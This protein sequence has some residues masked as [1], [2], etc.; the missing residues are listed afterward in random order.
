M[1]GEPK[2]WLDYLAQVWHVLLAFF[3][4]LMAV[5]ASGHAILKKRDT[6]AAV[7]WVAL[8]WLVPLLGPLLYFT[9]GINRLR[10]RA[11]QLRATHARYQTSAG[12]LTEREQPLDTVTR[13]APS[14]APLVRLGNQVVHQPLL[15]GN[16][17]EPLINGDAAFPAMVAAID[18]AKHTITFATYIFDQGKA[19]TMFVDA[20]SRAMQRGVEV[21][22]LIDDTGARYSW[23]SIVPKLK[24]A[25]IPVARFL[26]T[27]V[28]FRAMA[29]NLR[30]HRK[31]LV[32]DGHTAFTGGMNVR[33]GH[34]VAQKPKR[35]V[36]DVH[37]RLRGPVVS[38]LQEV[39]AD[40]WLFCTQEELRGEKWFPPL[41][42]AGPVLARSVPDGPDDH[43][44][45]IR[46]TILGAVSCAQKRIRIVNPYFLP[47]RGL[48]SALNVAALRGVQV[49]II[50]PQVNNLPFVHW[51]MMAQLWQLLERGCRVWLSEPPFDHSKLMVVDGEWSF[52]GSSNFD[53]RSLRLNFE[54]NVECYC[55]KLAADLE[56][57]I[58]SKLAKAHQ[59][60]LR[61]V[62]AR[63]L[64]I[65]LRDGVA[66]LLTPYL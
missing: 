4:L 26:P 66:R 34:L 63:P 59:L 24:Q 57:H 49:D 61:E 64:H 29:I 9:F 48:I 37:F 54:L 55:S 28:P 8:S 15:A 42:N 17:V 60:T 7:M 22:V 47:D 18:S 25:R 36:Q 16:S 51:A 53:P 19:G 1:G 50:L 32:I 14:L 2:D 27:S 12:S 38:Y 56:T 46:W 33:D 5:V 41:A 45:K 13:K 35:P 31:I 52:I 6:R 10:R 40:D 43:F 58:E 62:D 21:R 20:L 3:T 30:N 39:F 23:P 65:K 11:T 44:E